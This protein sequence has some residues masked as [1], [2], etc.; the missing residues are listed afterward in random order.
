M[1]YVV[2][3][4]S[5]SRLD[6]GKVT[7]EDCVYHPG[8]GTDAR[9]IGGKEVDGTVARSPP[10]E[11]K[12]PSSMQVGNAAEARRVVYYYWLFGT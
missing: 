7:E 5:V 3:V 2:Q 8:T 11:R 1:V 12:R 9:G 6:I 10:E 4:G